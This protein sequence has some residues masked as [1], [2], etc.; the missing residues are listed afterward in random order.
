[1]VSLPPCYTSWPRLAQPCWVWRGPGPRYG[2][3]EGGEPRLFTS[4]SRLPLTVGLKEQ[5]QG[6][7]LGFVHQLGV[8]PVQDDANII[9]RP[10]LN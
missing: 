1:M 10:R 2:P 7:L 8:I 3:S 4:Q 5:L 9:L 6:L